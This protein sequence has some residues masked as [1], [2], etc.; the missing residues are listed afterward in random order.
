MMYPGKGY[1][2]KM[3][4]QS[5]FSYDQNLF[6]FSNLN[7]SSFIYYNEVKSTGNNMT[8]ELKKDSWLGFSPE[9]GDEIAV[10]SKDGLLVGS[11]VYDGDNVAITLWGDDLST[12][13]I[14]GLNVGEQFLLKI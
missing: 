5:T 9:I 1:Q 4:E 3:L 2:I 8:L 11:Q 7:K 14:D 12:F 13:E 6:R 10:F